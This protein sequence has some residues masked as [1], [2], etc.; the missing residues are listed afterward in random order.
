MPNKVVQFA[1]VGCSIWNIAFGERLRTWTLILEFI[2]NTERSWHV[3]LRSRR[4]PPESFYCHRFSHN[5]FLLWLL[6]CSCC[7]FYRSVFLSGISEEYLFITEEEH[8]QQLD[9]KLS[10]Y[11]MVLITG[12]LFSASTSLASKNFI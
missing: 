5:S 11:K 3:P 6:V 2:N 7:T 8:I 12:K 9:S 10:F 1:Y 4:F